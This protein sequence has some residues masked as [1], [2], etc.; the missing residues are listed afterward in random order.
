MV[1]V[2]QLSKKLK[3]EMPIPR[4]MLEAFVANKDLQEIPSICGA[5]NDTDIGI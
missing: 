4:N 3:R 1:L 5:L 2:G